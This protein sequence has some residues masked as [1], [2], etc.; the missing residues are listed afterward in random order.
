MDNWDKV[1]PG[2]QAHMVTRAPSIIQQHDTCSAATLNLWTESL[3]YIM[4]LMG[5]MVGL[6]FG[7]TSTYKTVRSL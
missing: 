6:Q 3:D 5:K 2:W 4:P 7:I 1:C